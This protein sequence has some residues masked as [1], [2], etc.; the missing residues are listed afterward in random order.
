MS[1]D[2]RIDVFKDDFFSIY[3]VKHFKS[4]EYS[5]LVRC[6][7][8][9]EPP[10]LETVCNF[11]DRSKRCIRYF[12]GK[13]S[14]RICRWVRKIAKSDYWLRRVSVRPPVHTIRLFSPSVRPS[15][16]MEQHGYGWPDI[17]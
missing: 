17:H 1:L 6:V 13:K 14:S 2:E 8:Y 9:L 15:V 7:F 10:N 5:I 3:R 4:L 12:T 11:A 16:H